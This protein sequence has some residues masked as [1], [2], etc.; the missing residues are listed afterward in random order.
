MRASRP[1]RAL[2]SSNAA[3]PPSIQRPVKAP[4]IECV[5]ESAIRDVEYESGLVCCGKVLSICAGPGAGE[6]LETVDSVSVRCWT[7]TFF[8]TSSL[9]TPKVIR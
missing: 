7:E 4:F 8:F 3:S 6:E 5:A 9:R 1:M 2:V